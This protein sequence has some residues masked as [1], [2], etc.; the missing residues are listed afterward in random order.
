[1]KTTVDVVLYNVK[2]EN[3][4]LVKNASVILEL[5]FPEIDISFQIR[6]TPEAAKGLS[7]VL[8]EKARTCKTGWDDDGANP[9]I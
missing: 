5:V 8:Y 4:M 1:M 9:V 6:L 2:A 7:T 3:S